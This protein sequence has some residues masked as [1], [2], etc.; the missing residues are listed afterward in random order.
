MSKIGYGY[1]SEWHLLRY[2]GY[3]R[4]YLNDRIHDILDSDDIEWLDFDFSS[5]GGHLNDDKELEGVGFVGNSYTLSKWKDFWPTSGRQPSWDA[6]GKVKFTETSG[7]E[8]WLLVEAKAHVGEEV[9]KIG[10]TGKSR[11]KIRNALLKTMKSL[12]VHKDYLSVWLNK[13]YQYA[14]RLA[15]LHYLNEIM[16][17]PDSVH[18][19]N[20]F[21]YG[22]KHRGWYCPVTAD[23]WESYIEDIHYDMGLQSIREIGGLNRVHELYLPVNPNVKSKWDLL[24]ME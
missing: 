9:S 5:K 24:D 16:S 12:G 6:V 10:A 22:E 3:H 17:P 20:I 1:G 23:I 19:I 8:E 4:Q 14:N 21:F 18:L 15:V 11:L 2:L 13:Y 7:E